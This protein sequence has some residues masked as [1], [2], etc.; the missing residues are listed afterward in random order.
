MLEK[1]VIDAC[2]L[3]AMDKTTVTEALDLGMSYIDLVKIRYDINIEYESQK[4]QLRQY[5]IEGL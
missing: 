4:G 3:E 1:E 5:R 2:V